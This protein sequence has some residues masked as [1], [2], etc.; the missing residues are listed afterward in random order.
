VQ[1]L[2]GY[3]EGNI[4]GPR[5]ATGQLY[6]YPADA[7][8]YVPGAPIGSIQGVSYDTVQDVYYG[9]PT[10][11]NIATQTFFPNKGLTVGWNLN[12]GVGEIDFLCGRATGGPGGFNFLQVTNDGTLS[13][14]GVGGS[15]LANDGYGNTRLGGALVH[16]AMQSAPLVN[17]GTVTVNPSTSFV[18]IQNSTSIAAATIVLPA[19]LA[20]QYAAGAELELNFQNPVTAVT[21][22]PSG[23]GPTTIAQAGAS[24]LFIK[25]GTVWL[26]R[27]AI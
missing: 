4:Y 14:T 10:G 22:S 15:L 18:L 2:D 23:I 9:T 11:R 8:V 21:W 3:T 1:G 17:G 27:I 19:P 16:G 12:S 24:V 5:L 20:G 25:S 13:A 26:R 7:M 6:N